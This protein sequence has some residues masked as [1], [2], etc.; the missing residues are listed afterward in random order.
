M[1]L[2]YVA[3]PA[4]TKPAAVYWRRRFVVFGV[5]LLLVWFAAKACGGSGSSAS[6]AASN[7]QPAKAHPSAQTSTHPATAG[8]ATAP[9][10]AQVG[11]PGSTSSGNSTGATAPAAVTAMCDG[12]TLSLRAAVNRLSLH[13][14]FT[15]GITLQIATRSASPCGLDSGALRAQVLDGSRVLWSSDGCP[16]A[17]AAG[18]TGSGSTASSDAAG[19][20]SSAPSSGGTA[21]QS[22]ITVPSQSAADQHYT[23]HGNVCTGQL[24]PGRYDV[25]GRLG[26][27][28][29]FAGTVTVS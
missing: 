5:L 22:L 2:D 16:D 14:P 19:S 23:W 25:V 26:L 10:A 12:S 18:S 20:G 7:T 29:A 15:A 3:R 13:R 24:A 1:R 28:Q 8:H 17:G 9:S 6:R 27:A 11:T 4:G 21:T